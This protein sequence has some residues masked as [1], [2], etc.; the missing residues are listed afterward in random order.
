MQLFW[1]PEWKECGISIKSILDKVKISETSSIDF[2]VDFE[3]HLDD[4]QYLFS[5]VT[6]REKRVKGSRY[7]I[8][9]EVY[10]PKRPYHNYHLSFRWN[11]VKMMVDEI[12]EGL[13]NG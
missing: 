2:C 11:I 4:E 6:K 10:D 1:I 12:R 9:K 7:K 5:L 13:K 3:T 8:D